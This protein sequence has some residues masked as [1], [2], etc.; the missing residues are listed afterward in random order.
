ME[1]VHCHLA[2]PVIPPHERQVDIPRPISAMVMKL[3]AK[4]AEARY[5]STG[6]FLKVL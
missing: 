1:L 3:L 2:R 4:T 6:H 5:F